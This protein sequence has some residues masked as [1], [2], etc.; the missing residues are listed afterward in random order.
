MA[1]DLVTNCFS[2]HHIP[3]CFFVKT[4]N[5]KKRIHNWAFYLQEEGIKEDKGKLQN[6]QIRM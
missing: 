4:E 1:T 5:R 3:K 6:V 2:E